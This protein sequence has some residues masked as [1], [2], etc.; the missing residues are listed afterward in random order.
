MIRVS[1]NEVRPQ[2]PARGVK[3]W[4]LVYGSNLM[5]VYFEVD[6]GSRVPMHSHVHEQAGY[7]LKGRMVFRTPEGEVTVGEGESY[8]FKS[9]EPHEAYNPGPGKAVV[10][11]IF[12]PPREDFLK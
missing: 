5:V 1:R 2:E 10:L 6:E 3:R 7:I 11:E 12:S 9:N 4:I 8:I